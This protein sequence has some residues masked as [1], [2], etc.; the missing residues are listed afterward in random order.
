MDEVST[1]TGEHRMRRPHRKSRNGCSKCK[2]RRIKCD[3][4]R[5]K[6]SRCTKMDLPCEYPKRPSSDLLSA[7]DFWVDPIL[8]GA[9]TGTG[10]PDSSGHSS[11]MAASPLSSPSSS[12]LPYPPS[13][14]PLRSQ[15]AAQTL[16]PAEFELLQHYL[17][18]TCKDLTVDEDDQYALQI[19]IP[20][21]ACQSKPLMR[22]V[23][24]L[25]AICKCCDLISGPPRPVDRLKVQEFLALSDHYH[26]ESLHEIQTTLHESRHYD[27]VLANAAMMGMYGSASHRVRI[28]LAK[29]ATY[30]NPVGP[31]FVPKHCPWISLYRAVDIAYVGLLSNSSTPVGTDADVPDNTLG[32]LRPYEFKISPRFE[33]TSRVPTS[34][35][36]TIPIHPLGPVLAAT[37]GPAL[38]RLRE[39][40][41]E[42]V[43][44]QANT[45]PTLD[46]ISIA[47]NPELQTCF[48][49]LAILTTT[50]AETFSLP[51]LSETASSAGGSQRGGSG[52][53]TPNFAGHHFA[54]DV[55]IDPVGRLSELSPWLR[56]Y[57]ASITSMIPSRLPRRVIA[58]FIH[59]VSPAFLNLVEHV[60]NRMQTT[61]ATDG[62]QQVEMTDDPMSGWAMPES[63]ENISLAHQLAIEIFAHWL[64]LVILL[65]NVWWIGGIG[66]WEL[67]R[68]VQELRG[69]PR[70][71]SGCL[72]LSDENWWPESMLEISRQFDKHRTDI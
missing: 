62:S 60:I 32:I 65:D 8:L 22:S 55:D 53:G 71:W 70:R 66:S 36:S 16:A 40:A 68:L 34:G 52:S 43:M 7:D 27:A 23:L 35:P 28:W 37:V 24:A 50:I 42:I 5:P 56:R 2:D 17:E 6:C 44:L 18:H 64:V 11:A 10:S 25:A 33:S 13:P 19:G 9:S 49:A 31:D 72:W 45:D 51:S 57:T 26:M 1:G 12:R 3:E 15:I 39:K 69:Q 63:V 58:G 67:G 4:Q 59:K 30:A 54:F 38:A 29:T 48:S 61:N 41:N 20:S 14:L 46:A 21:L 47:N